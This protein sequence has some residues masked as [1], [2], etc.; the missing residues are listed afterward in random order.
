MYTD[1]S[2]V[3][4]RT[5]SL[6]KGNNVQIGEN[7][8]GIFLVELTRMQKIVIGDYCCFGPHVRVMPNRF[9]HNPDWMT[10]YPFQWDGRFKPKKKI[11]GKKRTGQTV[12]I[13]NDVWIGRD[14][15]LKTPVKIGDGAVIGAGA[16]VTKPVPPYAI[17]GG[18]PAKLIRF[19]FKDED[20][21]FLLKIK[22]WNWPKEK[23]EQ[24]LHLICSSNVDQLRKELGE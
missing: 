20:I 12:H 6:L 4:K 23:I 1:E 2:K 14:V 3:M 21:E 5:A 11:E 7:T 8:Y 19:R 10:I 18:V 15:L 13:G 16:V 9:G 22:W 17:V 24:Y